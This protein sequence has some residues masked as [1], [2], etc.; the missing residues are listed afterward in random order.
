MAILT[1]DFEGASSNTYIASWT[2]SGTISGWSWATGNSSTSSIEVRTNGAVGSDAAGTAEVDDALT[3]DHRVYA[4]FSDDAPNLYVCC[5]LVDEDNWVGFK[6]HGTGSLG[7]RTEERVGGG[8]V[9]NLQE[10]IFVSFND[11]YMVETDGDQLYTAICGS[12]S[13]PGAVT[14]SLYGPTTNSNMSSTEQSVGI[15]ATGS[16][17][18]GAFLEDFQCEAI[19][20]GPTYTLTADAGSYTWSGAAA[21]LTVA[22]KLTAG[23]GS[24]AWA[25]G[26]ATLAVGRKLT[27]E[28]GAYSWTGGDATFTYTPAGVTYTLI[29]DAGAYVFSGADAVLAV[30]RKLT[31]EAGAYAFTGAD[32][33]LSRGF[34]LQAEAG[35]Y[36]FAGADVAFK[37]SYAL[38]A[39]AG[40]YTFT[41]SDVAF[42]YSGQGLWTQISEQSTTWTEVADPSTT[43]TEV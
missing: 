19:S 24:Y 8:A 13:A 25:G 11:W 4:R 20:A 7:L 37:R 42:S 5:R 36:V 16:T 17:S 28:A 33:N 27:A 38:Q 2:P 34:A 32:A 10:D 39:D 23:A 1:D 15:C 14:T 30:G 6:V 21:G 26:D 31:A 35:S 43:W 12:G 29:A 40:T 9:S 41:G 18:T 3:A 22:R